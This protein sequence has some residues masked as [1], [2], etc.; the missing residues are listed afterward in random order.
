MRL[1]ESAQ[2]AV[3]EG[4]SAGIAKL[5]LWATKTPSA[6]E[7]VDDPGNRRRLNCHVFARICGSAE[8]GGSP[9]DASSPGVGEPRIA[10]PTA[11]AKPHGHRR[12]TPPKSPQG[13]LRLLPPFSAA[14][15]ADAG[16]PGSAAC[17]DSR[18][19]K[20]GRIPSGGRLPPSLHAS[21]GL[22]CHPSGDRANRGSTERGSGRSRGSSPALAAARRIRDSDT[23]RFAA[24][25]PRSSLP[26]ITTGVSGA[27]GS[28]QKSPPSFSTSLPDGVFVTHRRNRH[29]GGRKLKLRAPILQ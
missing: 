9:P 20:S 17:A 10:A 4:I 29:G 5:H 14:S 24:P 11:G 8:P 23:D 13:L 18:P 28:S 6:P 2:V 15:V 16:Q 22:K 27:P 12:T 19:R 3:A 26:C 25:V 21:G 7:V 1:G